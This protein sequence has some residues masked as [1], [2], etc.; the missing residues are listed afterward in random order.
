LIFS[1]CPSQHSWQAL[2]AAVQGHKNKEGTKNIL[3]SVLLIY[4]FFVSSTGRYLSIDLS[5]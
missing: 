5:C 2:T 3:C 4:F 1:L